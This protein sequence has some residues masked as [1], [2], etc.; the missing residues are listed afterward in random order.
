[1]E[2]AAVAAALER[3]LNVLILDSVAVTLQQFSFWR[4]TD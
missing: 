3:E 4:W 2:G 1:M